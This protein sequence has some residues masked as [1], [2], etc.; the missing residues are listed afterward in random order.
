MSWF[1]RFDRFLSGHMVRS[2]DLHYSCGMACIVMVNFKIKKGL[3]FAGMSAGAALQVVPVIGSYLGAT[4][5][6]S[7]FDYAV[8]SEKEVY[9]LAEKAKGS[10]ND[11]NVCG[12]SLGLYPQ[13]LADLGLGTWECVNVGEGGIVQA[14]IDSTNAGAPVI[15][16]THW[17]A[18]GDHAVCVDE[19]HSFFGT[20]YLCVC[21][22]GDGELRL[23]TGTAG[24]TVR[25]DGGD[26]PISTHTIFGGSAI[27]YTPGANNKGK[28]DG[29]IVRRK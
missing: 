28:F 29:W 13:V 4:L 11:F 22:P 6:Q 17:D 7:A 1:S 27:G 16:N 24:S 19:T 23:I 3:M 25:Y 2:Q 20:R 12:V 15:L 10:P 21:D 26:T 5:A 8:A 18:G 9:A 14:C